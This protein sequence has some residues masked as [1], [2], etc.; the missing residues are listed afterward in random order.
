LTAI[1]IL[2]DHFTEAYNETPHH[3]ETILRVRNGIEVV[4]V[5]VTAGLDDL[6]SDRLISKPQAYVSNACRLFLRSTNALN[7]LESIQIGLER[8]YRVTFQHKAAWLLT[9]S[10]QLW[11]AIG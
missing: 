5:L 9:D 11:Q 2:K 3:I 6:D 1:E 4:I 10:M 8:K 7:V